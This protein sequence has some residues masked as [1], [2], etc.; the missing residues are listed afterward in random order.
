MS[1]LT[2]NQVKDTY[3][4]LLKLE[5]NGSLS[6]NL[7]II[8]DG[9]GN[10]TPLSISTTAISSSV[11]I[12]ATGFKTPGGTASD[13]LRADGSTGTLAIPTNTDGLTEG[14]TNLYNV[15]HTGDVTGAT[16]LTIANGVVTNAKMAVDSIDS[17]QYIDGSI[18]SIH[19]A[20]DVISYAKMGTEFTTSAVVGAADIDFATAQVFTK[21]LTVATTFTFTNASIGMVKDLI[22]TGD[23][24]PTFPA[25]SKVVT[26][27][28]NGTV[29]NFIQ[30]VVVGTGDYWLSI[31][32][33]I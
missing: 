7:K 31:S 14:V 33:S 18:D 2:G 9:I 4:S 10:S 23:F 12:Q 32:Q 6:A 24:A 3:R 22:L 19:L 28:Y 25:G 15:T 16:A 30:I 5:D 8:Q 26:G 11:N 29:S 21:T 13:Y 1:T 27:T 20:D 17:D